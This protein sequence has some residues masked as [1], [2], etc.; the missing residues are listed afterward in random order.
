MPSPSGE[1]RSPTS[2]R[3]SKFV[4]GYASVVAGNEPCTNARMANANGKPFEDVRVP[5]GLKPEHVVHAVKA[6]FAPDDETHGP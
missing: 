1:S 3:Q 4:G 6:R 2:T 5:I